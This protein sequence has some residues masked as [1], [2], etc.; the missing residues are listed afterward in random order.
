MRKR[1]AFEGLAKLHDVLCLPV[2]KLLHEYAIASLHDQ[3]ERLKYLTWAWC[4]GVFEQALGAEECV[5]DFPDLECRQRL[6][7]RVGPDDSEVQALLPE[8]IR[9]FGTPQVFESEVDFRQE[10]LDSGKARK[11]QPLHQ[12]VAATDGE[13]HR[14]IARPQ[15]EVVQSANGLAGDLH[16]L[17]PILSQ[18]QPFAVATGQLDSEEI[19]Q[20]LDL[21]A[22][23]ALP[24]RIVARR[25]HEA[26]RLGDF[27]KHSQAVH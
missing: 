20:F 5:R 8:A 6:G 9:D 3:R 26:A 13:S 24:H 12:T 15:L 18:D 2:S 22:E 16:Q 17:F 19:L 11:N 23:L 7:K 14:L 1:V 25:P 10:F 27:A 21:A 4:S